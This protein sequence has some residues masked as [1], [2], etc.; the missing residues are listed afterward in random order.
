MV[1]RG[2]LY[3]P[4]VQTCAVLSVIGVL[5]MLAAMLGYYGTDLLRGVY[6]GTGDVVMWDWL[7]AI[8]CGWSKLGVVAG[9]V[10]GLAGGLSRGGGLVGA[11]ATL[12]VPASL[13][14]PSVLAGRPLT[15]MLDRPGP[16][17]WF[18]LAALGVSAALTLRAVLGFAAKTPGHTPLATDWLGVTA[19]SDRQRRRRAA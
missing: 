18:L 8:W 17:T 13:L 10:C 12:A 2:V 11:L 14:Y 6:A 16:L 19:R 3:R 15:S 4:H 5:G 1:P 7:W 9:A